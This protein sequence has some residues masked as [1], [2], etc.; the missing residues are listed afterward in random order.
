VTFSYGGQLSAIFPG[1][2]SGLAFLLGF[3]AALF[4]FASVLAHELGHSFVALWQGLKLNPSA[5]FSLG[6]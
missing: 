3:V 1:L 5:Y 2:A 4:L 6:V